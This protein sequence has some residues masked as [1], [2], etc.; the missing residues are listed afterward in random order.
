MDFELC[1]GDNTAPVTS[2]CHLAM[3]SGGLGQARKG[4]ATA[5]MS[6]VRTG[7]RESHFSLKTV[8]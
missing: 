5:V 6:C 3:N 7:W 1:F 2:V 8:V 4:A